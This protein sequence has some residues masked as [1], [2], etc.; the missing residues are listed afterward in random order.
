MGVVIRQGLKGTFW[1]YIGVLLGA[2][3]IM[4]VFPY[5]LQPEEIGIYRVVIDLGSLFAIFAGLG[6]A[7]IADRFYVKI[8]D[9]FRNSFLIFILGA[10]FLGFVL[11][12][13]IYWLF[14]DYFY[15]LFADN[16]EVLSEYKI[17]ILILTGCFVFLSIYDS[18]YRVKLNIIYPVFSREILLRVVVLIATI[19][20]GAGVLYFSG[21]MLWVLVSYVV[22]VVVL[23]FL[24]YWKYL[25]Q[26]EWSW[27]WPSRSLAKELSAYAFVI[28]IGGGSA[29]LISKI[30]VLMIVGMMPDGLTQVAVYALG[31]FIASIIEIPRRSISQISTPLISNAW[32]D[33]DTNYLHDVYARS[34]INLLVIGGWIFILIW[35]S[36]NDLISIIPQHELYAGCKQVVF[37]VGLGKVINM[38][39]GLCS[40]IILQSKYYR[41]NIYSIFVLVI[42][43]SVFNYIFIPWYGIEG[44]AMGTALA[45]FLYNALKMAFMYYQLK[46]NPFSWNLLLVIGMGV[47][48]WL[49]FYFIHYAPNSLVMIILW[50]SLKSLI[51][52]VVLALLLYFTKVAPDFN[53]I[54]NSM[55]LKLGLK[56]S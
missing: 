35:I 23:L 15:Q 4:W 26:N 49:P 36:I 46:S 2:L 12:T 10:G 28:L 42:L 52:S 1:N 31:F 19:G 34:V 32:H 21:F 51:V 30:D 55:L 25:K 17:D 29:V 47:L 48:L 39:S 56:K 50:V 44:A 38:A 14:D 54:M 37:W 41:F 22:A 3:N 5:Y 43:I 45:I 6:T 24:Y 11:F 18:L 20:V 27:F 53:H 13:G 7:N 16:A 40:E 9:R 8:E 33:N